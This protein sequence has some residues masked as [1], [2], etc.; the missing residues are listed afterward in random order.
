MYFLD[1]NDIVSRTLSISSIETAET[2]MSKSYHGEY[3]GIFRR[4]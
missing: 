2:S 1:K 4:F 3:H